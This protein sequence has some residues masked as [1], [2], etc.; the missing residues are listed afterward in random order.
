MNAADRL[1]IRAMQREVD[2]L[3]LEEQLHAEV[4]ERIRAAQQ[5]PIEYEKTPE[6]LAQQEAIE[7]ELA[8]SRAARKRQSD[9]EKASKD[10]QL[11]Q[12]M[13]ERMIINPRIGMLRSLREELNTLEPSSHVS[14]SAPVEVSQQRKSVTSESPR[15]NRKYSVQ[16]REAVRLG[17][18]KRASLQELRDQQ[19]RHAEE[20][21]LRASRH[22]RDLETARAAAAAAE[23][24]ERRY[25]DMRQHLRAAV[26]AEV[27]GDGVLRPLS[28]IQVE[29][30]DLF[31]EFDYACDKEFGILSESNASLDEMMDAFRDQPHIWC[32]FT[33]RCQSYFYQPPEESAAPP[34]AARRTSTIIVE[35]S[36]TEENVMQADVTHLAAVSSAS[37]STHQKP[38]E[39]EPTIAAEVVPEALAECR[40][41]LAATREPLHAL[42]W[43]Q[44]HHEEC[45]RARH[46]ASERLRVE[47]ERRKDA[48]RTS[49]EC[50]TVTSFSGSTSALAATTTYCEIQQLADTAAMPQ[51]S[52]SNTLVASRPT[53][54]HRSVFDA[55]TEFAQPRDSVLSR[56][57]GT[58]PSVVP[59]AASQSGFD[60]VLPAAPDRSGGASYSKSISRRNLSKILRY[61][62]AFDE[63]FASAG[64][65][66]FFDNHG[67]HS[68][69]PSR[70]LEESGLSDLP[71]GENFLSAVYSSNH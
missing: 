32:F 47:R 50:E 4:Q 29:Q 10:A 30:A 55:P 9:E 8:L 57:L 68:R 18:L 61:N 71:P 22:A 35:D 20:V 5:P 67:D 7:A 33:N 62:P 45:R 25:N 41:L 3:S 37:E 15:N 44:R 40:S 56:A 63:S 31:L 48:R 24:Y 1:L 66:K 60:I 46:E 14:S 12:T 2:E 58:A 38:F 43:E 16:L 34:A 52:A 11:E 51:S 42:E 13:R 36:Q 6:Y 26:L 39:S 21:A 53:S 19:R 59:L 27:F 23:E 64:T 17:E 65:Q 49:S 69:E 28:P 70:N 54:G